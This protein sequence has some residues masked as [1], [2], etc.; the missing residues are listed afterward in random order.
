MQVVNQV[1]PSGERM[2]EFFGGEEDGPFVMVNL[3]K[4]KASAE[5]PDGRDT[6]L[7]GAEAY[8]IYARGV[9]PLVEKH[10]G[11]PVFDG[12]VTGLMLGEVEDNW[13]MVA[14][15]EY[16]SLEAFRAMILSS[17][18]QEIA[19][20]RAAGLEGQLNIKTQASAR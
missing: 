12:T 16:P 1:N 10:G 6:E 15:V 9:F 5:Y 20:H 11:R 2:K 17:E 18:Y 13:D 19:V 14:L 4:F 3:L 8:A 7:S